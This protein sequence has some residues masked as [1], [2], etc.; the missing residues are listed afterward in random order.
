LAPLRENDPNPMANELILLIEDHEK[1][2]KLD[3]AR[4][5]FAGLTSR[6]KVA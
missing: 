3:H 4:P 6:A 2:R 5:T 1:S